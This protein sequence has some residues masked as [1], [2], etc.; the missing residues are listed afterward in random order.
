MATQLRPARTFDVTPGENGIG[1]EI[2][3]IQIAGDL[4]DED[5]AAIEAALVAHKV[6]FFRDQAM[7]PQQMLAFGRRFGPLEIH[8]FAS[9]KTFTSPPEEPELE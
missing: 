7:T 8:P 9:F 4:S 6:L 5:I 2:S 1:A 3:G